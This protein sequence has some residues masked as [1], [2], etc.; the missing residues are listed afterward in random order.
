MI[1]DIIRSNNFDETGATGSVENHNMTSTNI[2]SDADPV[3]PVSNESSLLKGPILTQQSINRSM[4]DESMA[5]VEDQQLPV[6]EE[7][8]LNEPQCQTHYTQD[9]NSEPSL[10]T[11]NVHSNNFDEK[12][13]TGS[14]ENHAMTHIRMDSA[15]QMSTTS[16][17]IFTQLSEDTYDHRGKCT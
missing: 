14:V 5:V 17:N 15:P 9:Y 1:P 11:D 6:E 12:N 4:E 7:Q 10:T 13:A 16:T 2:K 8:L 3:E